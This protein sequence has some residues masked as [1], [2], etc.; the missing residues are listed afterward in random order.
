M[1]Q[2]VSQLGTSQTRIGLGS[3]KN[4]THKY[5]FDILQWITLCIFVFV[6]LIPAVEYVPQK[7]KINPSNSCNW[8]SNSFEMIRFGKS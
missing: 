5:H 4:D 7:I 1:N 6:F 8:L 2:S 3:D